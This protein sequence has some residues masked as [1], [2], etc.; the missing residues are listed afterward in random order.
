[1]T[2]FEFAFIL[3]ALLLDLSM[4]ELLA[5]LGRALELKFASDAGGAN[6]TIGWLTPALAIFVMLDL[7]SF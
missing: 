6:F 3:Y 4:I 7:L 2:D 5:G 1:M